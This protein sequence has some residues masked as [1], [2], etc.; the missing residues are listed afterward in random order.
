MA[1]A[2]QGLSVL[3]NDSTLTNQVDTVDADEHNTHRTN[4]RTQIDAHK[5]VLEEQD[6]NYASSSEPTLKSEGKLYCDTTSDPAKMKY[7][8]D[9]SSNLEEVVGTTLTQILT[10]KTLTSP[11]ITSPTLTTPTFTAAGAK[12]SIGLARDENLVI[13]NNATNP[14]YQ[15]DITFDYWTL[16]DTSNR[17]VVESKT[18]A[19][20]LDIATTGAGG[21]AASENSGSEKSDDWY[22]VYVY[23]NGSGTINGLLSL[24]STWATV[25]SGDKPS[26]SDFVQ[27]IGAIR[28]NSSGDIPLF[29][30]QDEEVRVIKEFLGNYTALGSFTTITDFVP[31]Y[32][33]QIE[34]NFYSGS[35]SYTESGTFY[36]HDDA[37]VG[38][39]GYWVGPAGITIATGLSITNQWGVIKVDGSTRKVA[40][41]NN[42]TASTNLYIVGWKF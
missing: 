10:N 34:L 19:L 37:N 40:V 17:G 31:E 1:D 35:A 28:N 4:V 26:G 23:S 39:V 8:K 6:K 38:A 15:I 25:A 22:Y 3:N 14:T 42:H 24:N 41:V 11:T 29:Y 33:R 18:S 27:R 20:T 16:Y 12:G 32:A 2:I 36:V 13:I 9:S 30:Q 21:R 7:Y 5:T